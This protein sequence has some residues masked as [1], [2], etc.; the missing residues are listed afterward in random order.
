MKKVTMMM[1]L[2]L[3]LGMFSACNSNDELDVLL[4]EKLTL[5]EDS[6]QNVPE[7]E[8]V[9]V[10]YLVLL[11]EVRHQARCR[12]VVL[13]AGDFEN[14][15]LVGERC[16]E[17]AH[18]HEVAHAVVHLVAVARFHRDTADPLD[19]VDAELDPFR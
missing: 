13:G 2:L 11:V 14:V 19:I 5:F 4:D 16:R 3:T 18:I 6:L 15:E 9:H 1:S 10:L 7:E 8:L 17:G 12:R